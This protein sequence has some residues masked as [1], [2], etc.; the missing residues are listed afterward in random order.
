MSNN[1]N[2]SALAAMAPAAG[3]GIGKQLAELLLSE[4]GFPDLM[5]KVALD[6]L[7]ATTHRWE[8]G[9]KETI[10]IP[11]YKTR[12]QMFFGLLAHMEGEPVK[13]IIHQHIGNGGVDT[14][15]ALQESPALLAA[16]EREV[17]KARWRSSGNAAHKRPGAAAPRIGEAEI[18]VE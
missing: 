18:V 12:A 15:A 9:L 3:A 11:D 4:P 16:V 14:L 6:C 8:P 13:R 10:Y 7:N 17:A 1:A 5:R 2:S